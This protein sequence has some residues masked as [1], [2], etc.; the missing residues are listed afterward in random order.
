MATYII[1]IDGTIA[2]T[3]HRQW[4]LE[5]KRPYGPNWDLFFSLAAD[6]TPFEHMRQLV[7]TLSDL[8][9][10]NGDAR[11]NILYVSGRPERCRS[12]TVK[13]LEQHD[14]PDGYQL[15]MRKDGDHRPDTVIKK[16]ILQFIR[17]AGYNPSMAFDDRNAVV[18]MWRA[19]GVPCAQVAEG[20]F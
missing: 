18:A 2:D 16:E 11:N 20:N 3:A 19:N 17:D 7:W 4:V 6:D 1:D 15:W 14:F 9:D 5:E 8:D 12:L 13:W 10:E